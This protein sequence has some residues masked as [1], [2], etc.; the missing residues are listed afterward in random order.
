M[1][2]QKARVGKIGRIQYVEKDGNVKQ[3]KIKTMLATIRRRKENWLEHVLRG[4]WL[5]MT[6]L[7]RTVEGEVKRSQRRI[8]LIDDITEKD[9]YVIYR[10]REKQGI[11]RQW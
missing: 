9:K 7:D 11:G 10:W 5:L 2:A 6:V 1:Y 3:T 8:Q 4:K